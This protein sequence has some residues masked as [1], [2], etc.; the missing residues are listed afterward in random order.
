MLPPRGQAR[1][2]PTYYLELGYIGGNDLLGKGSGNL[3]NASVSGTILELSGEYGPV[4]PWMAF[5]FISYLFFF[6]FSLI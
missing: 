4:F 2:S 5:F 6:H 1:I 3:A